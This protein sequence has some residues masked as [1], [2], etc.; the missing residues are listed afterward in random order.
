MVERTWKLLTQKF[1]N[2]ETNKGEKI[3]IEIKQSLIRDDKMSIIED[4]E[5]KK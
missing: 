5:T 4:T 2:F 3:L 1:I